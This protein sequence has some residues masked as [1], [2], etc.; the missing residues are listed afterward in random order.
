M[1]SP[2]HLTLHRCL[3]TFSHCIAS[4]PFHLHRLGGVMVPSTQRKHEKRLPRQQLYA[5]C[6][7]LG[8]WPI[9]AIADFASVALLSPFPS[10]P[11]AKLGQKAVCLPTH[12]PIFHTHL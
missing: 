8:N 12:L 6:V 1:Q 5:I 2:V 11:L 9:A 7:T 4:P 10:P 3:P